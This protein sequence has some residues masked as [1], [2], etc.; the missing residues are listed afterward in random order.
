MKENVCAIF[1]NWKVFAHCIIVL[2]KTLLCIQKVLISQACVEVFLNI[3][4]AYSTIL[5]GE[6]M[7]IVFNFYLENINNTLYPLRLISTL[8][9]NFWICTSEFLNICQIFL[10]KIFTSICSVTLLFYP[11]AIRKQKQ[12]CEYYDELMMMWMGQKRERR[13]KFWD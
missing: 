7:I 6:I 1:D 12:C 5:D 10:N 8:I 13:S 11:K 3:Q 2:E 4:G 9:V